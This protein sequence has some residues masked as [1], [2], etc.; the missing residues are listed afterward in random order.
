MKAVILAGGKGTRL[1]P[2]TLVWPK[3]LM[4]LG[5]YFIIDVVF[6]QL[7]YY[8][9]TEI[10]MAVGHLNHL[11][12]KYLGEE[13]DGLKI[14]YSLEEEPLGTA[15]P[16]G[17]IPNLF[18]SPFLVMNGDVLTTLHYKNL[19]DFH[20]QSQALASIATFQRPISLGFGAVKKTSDGRVTEYK[21]KPVFHYAVSMGVYAFSPEVGSYIPKGQYLDFPD[22]IQRLIQDG[23]KVSAYQED[24]LWLDIGRQE[25][26]NQAVQKFNHDIHLY[27]PALS[28]H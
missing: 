25:D 4:P 18:E 5:K 6:H 2:Y 19:M 14:H 9:F 13:K 22:L 3:P 20:I 7:K 28:S 21:E 26:Y 11:L 1:R 15:G 24:C 17:L 8:G 16:L 23:K 10:Y 27:M 12:R